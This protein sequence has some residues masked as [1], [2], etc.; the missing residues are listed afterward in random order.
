[1]MQKDTSDVNLRPLA[2]GLM[3]VAAVLRVA[4]NLNFAP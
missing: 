3:I 2:I 4:Q 1:M